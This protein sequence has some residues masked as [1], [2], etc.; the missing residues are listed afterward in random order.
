MSAS[1][2]LSE[3]FFLKYITAGAPAVKM[4]NNV[5]FWA[6]GELP[7]PEYQHYESHPPFI[8]PFPFYGC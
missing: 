7:S 4:E 5:M 2:G 1:V 3:F 8:S 6:M